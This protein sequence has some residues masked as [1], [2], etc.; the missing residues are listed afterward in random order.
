MTILIS[1]TKKITDKLCRNLQ[2][3]DEIA[4]RTE[5][6][7]LVLNGSGAYG[8]AY[9]YGYVTEAVRNALSALDAL[10]AEAPQT[11]PRWTKA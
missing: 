6:D 11:T 9:A 3:A 8:Y 5:D 2:V 7:P 10:H 1:A 4:K